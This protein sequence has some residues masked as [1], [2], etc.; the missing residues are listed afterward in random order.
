MPSFIQE[1]IMLGVSNDAGTHA[2]TFVYCGQ[3]IKVRV[4]MYMLLAVKSGY[5]RLRLFTDF[6]LV[7]LYPCYR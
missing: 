4:Q 7:F 3:M 2:F 1:G 6:R 5:G